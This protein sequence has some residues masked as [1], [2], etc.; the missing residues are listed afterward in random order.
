MQLSSDSPEHG[1][2]IAAAAELQR[3]IG[4]LAKV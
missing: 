4:E 1:V 3:Q 2:A